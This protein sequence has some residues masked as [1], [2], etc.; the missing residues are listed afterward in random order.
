[1]KTAIFA[2]VLSLAASL[3]SAAIV[4]TP[5]TDDQIVEKMAGDCPFGV[6]T[7]QGCGMR[8]A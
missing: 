5:I 3:A 1:M 6:V 2:L 7:P 8:R 4:I